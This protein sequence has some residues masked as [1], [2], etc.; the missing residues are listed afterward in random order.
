MARQRLQ[1]IIYTVHTGESLYSISRRYHITV[2]EISRENPLVDLYN[3]EAGDEIFIPIG[4]GGTNRV[5]E[6]QVTDHETLQMVLNK[7]NLE[8]D[9]L[10]KYNDLDT[11]KLFAGM[12]LHIP[13]RQYECQYN[14]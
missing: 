12:T 5:I 9:E 6:Y 2:A 8:L 4:F 13:M 3:L 1:G 10:L 14:Q 11:L 7:F